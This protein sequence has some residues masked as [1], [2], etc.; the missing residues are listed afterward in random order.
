MKYVKL[1]EEYLNKGPWRG[2]RPV[3]DKLRGR[4][5]HASPSPINKLTRYPMWFALEKSHSDGWFNNIIDWNGGHESYQYSCTISGKVGD[6]KDSSVRKIL[7][8]VGGN[9][10]NYTADL[11]SNPS[12]VEVMKDKRTNALIKAG[13][14]GLTYYDYDPNDF[15][16]PSLKALIVFNP[17]KS[18]KG[19]KIIDKRE[20]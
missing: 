12:S 17:L 18:V 1:Y 20:K 3:Q 8:D 19:W 5:Y 16:G 9:P 11:T 4:V 14:V 15:Q 6:I 10:D 7:A 2:L 13:Y